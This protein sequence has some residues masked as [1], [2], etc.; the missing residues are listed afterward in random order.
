VGTDLVAGVFGHST[1][2]SAHDFGCAALS[3]RSSDMSAA[4]KAKNK[5]DDVVAEAAKA[6]LR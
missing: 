6:T 3:T 2:T 4:D 5:V 1:T